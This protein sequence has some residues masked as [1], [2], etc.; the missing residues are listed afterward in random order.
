MS[1]NHNDML[2]IKDT[3]AANNIFFALK[4]LC[5]VETPAVVKANMFPP[6]K[7]GQG[8]GETK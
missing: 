2:H 1:L 3:N 8:E 6:V 7:I 4:K 5:I